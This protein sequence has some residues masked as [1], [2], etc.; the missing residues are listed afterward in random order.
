MYILEVYNERS[1]AGVNIARDIIDIRNA[2]IEIYN[3]KSLIP[4]Y[5]PQLL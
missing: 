3:R 5:Q 1:K 4:Y 2:I